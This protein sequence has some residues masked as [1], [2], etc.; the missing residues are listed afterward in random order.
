MSPQG[1]RDLERSVMRSL[2]AALAANDA[3]R[4]NELLD[5]LLQTRES[6]IQSE[7]VRLAGTL[8]DALMRFRMDSRVA[9]LAEKDIPDA[10]QRLDHVVTLTEEAAHRTLD[11]IERSV[12]LADATA[13]RAAE[14]AKSGSEPAVLQA[15]LTEARVNCEAVRSNLTEVML[16]QGFQDITGQIIRGV[17][18][19]IGEV[20]TVLDDLM[21][22]HGIPRE[23]IDTSA[24]DRLKLE[25]PTVPGVTRNAVN[26]QNAIDDLMAGLGL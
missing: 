10:R 2:N 23:V 21:S 9:A 18:K 17:H 24:A 5:Q 22:V 26:D 20:E 11:L 6:A 4:F 7:V 16:A 1:L 3:P 19:L 13:R 15:F 14:I 8:Q 12:P 25:G